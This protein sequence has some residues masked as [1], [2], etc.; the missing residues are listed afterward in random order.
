LQV[1]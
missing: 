1:A